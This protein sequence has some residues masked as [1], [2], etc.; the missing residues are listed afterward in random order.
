MNAWCASIANAEMTTPSMSWCGSRS[1]SM[2]SLN[3]DGS[4]SSPLTT[5][6][7][8]VDVLREERPLLAAAEPGAAPAPQPRRLHLLLGSRRASSSAPCAAPRSRRWRGS[9]S[10]VH[11]SSGCSRSRFVTMRVSV[12]AIRLRSSRAARRPRAGPRVRPRLYSSTIALGR[13]GRE[14]AVELVVHLEHG[15]LSHAARHSTSSTYT[16]SSSA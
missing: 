15:A 3:V 10:M 2:W 12:T 13:L 6:Y 4:P 9:A 11:E 1:M 5:R 16:S 14:R 8:R 7:A